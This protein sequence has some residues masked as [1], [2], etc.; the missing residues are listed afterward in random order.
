MAQEVEHLPSKCEALSSTANAA[1]KFKK[2][3]EKKNE[4]HLKRSISGINWTSLLV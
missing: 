4:I 2:E 3:I 1:K